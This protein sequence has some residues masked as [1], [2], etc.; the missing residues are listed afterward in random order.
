MTLM[1]LDKLLCI[2]RDKQD[3]DSAPYWG[4]LTEPTCEEI[5]DAIQNGNLVPWEKD[6]DKSQYQG[7]RDWHIGRIA[8]L[9][10]NWKDDYPIG[11]YKSKTDLDGGHRLYAAHHRGIQ[12]LSTIEF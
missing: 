11:L 8:W 2:F 6:G 3:R 4:C 1:A 5:S 9:V 12:A 7:V 10:V